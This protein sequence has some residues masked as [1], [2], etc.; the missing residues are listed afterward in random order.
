MTIGE[1]SMLI[2]PDI[3]ATPD[4]PTIKFNQPRDQVDL[5]K[6]LPR[7]LHAQGW[8]CGTLF[9]I[10]FL[11]HDKTKLLACG[12][13][14]VC[15]EIETIQTNDANPYQPMTKTVFSR[16]AVQIGE[17]WPTV[18]LMLDEGFKETSIVHPPLI[19]K[20]AESEV[21]KRKYVRRT[22]LNQ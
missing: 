2:Y 9:N 6:E 10:M 22:Q 17:W 13:F 3:Q 1:N 16:V 18:G 12:R 15:E 20:D 19:K 11:N 5:H 14:V 8:G 7:I 4:C 21:P